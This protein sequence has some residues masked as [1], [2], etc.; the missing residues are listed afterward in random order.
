MALNITESIPDYSNDDPDSP[1]Y[2]S[3]KR[4]LLYMGLDTLMPL[5]GIPLDKV[6]IGSCTNA[7]LEE[8]RAAANIVKGKKV[9]KNI[10][11]ALVVLVRFS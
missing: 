5:E 9:A 8:L 4:A 11:Q 1:A 7:R 2:Q 10:T 3:M 6:F